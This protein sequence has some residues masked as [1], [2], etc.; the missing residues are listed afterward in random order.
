M[1]RARERSV[2]VGDRSYT[3]RR[4]SDADAAVFSG[5]STIEILKR[6]VVGWNL[7]ELDLLPGGGGPEPVPFDADVWAIH[8]VD[9]PDLWMPLGN[10]ILEDY[11]KHVKERER[12]EKN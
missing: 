1:L 11:E 7:V 12:L 9:H 8:V 2:P 6:F 4:P 3:I 5:L 10:A